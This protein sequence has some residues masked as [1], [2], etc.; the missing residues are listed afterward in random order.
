MSRVT[1]AE[2]REGILKQEHGLGLATPQQIHEG[3]WCMEPQAVLGR[4]VQEDQRPPASFLLLLGQR[5]GINR[6]PKPG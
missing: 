3:C 1:K 2:R 6:Q 4:G 5:T